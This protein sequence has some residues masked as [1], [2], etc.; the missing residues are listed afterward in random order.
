M[1]KLSSAKLH[2]ENYAFV[3]PLIF[4]GDNRFKTLSGWKLLGY[5]EAPWPGSGPKA[6]CYEK[7]TPANEGGRDTFDHLDFG[8]Y[9]VHGNPDTMEFVA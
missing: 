1:Q 2:Q 3:H 9:W 6:I 5:A 8:I 4:L 7:L